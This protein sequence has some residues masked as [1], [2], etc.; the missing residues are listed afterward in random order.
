MKKNVET[1]I[2]AHFWRTIHPLESFEPIEGSTLCLRELTRTRK[3][4]TRHGHLAE[5]IGMISKAAAIGF[6]T[7]PVRTRVLA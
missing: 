4:N 5:A 7:T 1:L 2:L 6:E 3:L